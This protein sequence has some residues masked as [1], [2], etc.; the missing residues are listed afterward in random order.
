MDISAQASPAKSPKA[1]A[2]LDAI[3]GR[4][5]AARAVQIIGHVRPDGDCIGSMLAMHHLIGQWGIASAMAAQEMPTNGY[6]ALERFDRIQSEP[7]PALNPDLV[8]YVDCATLDRGFSEWS[9]P[10]PIINIDHHRSNSCYGQI[11]WIDPESAA[12]GEMLY[13]LIEHAQASLTIPMAEALLVAITT[14][15]GSFRF[16]NTGPRQHIIRRTVD[17]G[18]G[19]GRADLAH[20]IWKPSGGEHLAHRACAEHDAA[21]VR[22]PNWPGVKSARTFTSDMAG[23]PMRPRTWPTLL[24]GV[25]GVK[26]SL[27]FHEMERWG[28]A[29]TEPQ[30]E[31]RCRRGADCGDL[32]GR[33]PPLRRRR[34][35]GRCRL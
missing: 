11:N 28:I 8:V 20:C 34:L 9:P 19:L 25:L 5:R 12:T 6:G 35:P 30:V 27:L 17:R 18:G 24:R 32:G 23:R 26:V 7:D 3:V 14:D 16:S 10:A 21:G 13:Q 31:W 4:L 33:R 29:G 15:T 2:P 1:P 22:R